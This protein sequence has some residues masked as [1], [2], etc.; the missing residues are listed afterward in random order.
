MA[1]A[2]T[3]FL[4]DEKGRKRL[5]VLPIKECH[6]LLQDLEDLAVMAERKEET[7]ELLEVVKSKLEE[8]WRHTGS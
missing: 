7:T 1:R 2:K 5:V 8:K 3:H 4:V 6:E